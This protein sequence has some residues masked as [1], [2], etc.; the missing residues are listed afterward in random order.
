MYIGWWIEC[1]REMQVWKGK[2]LG[3]ANAGVLVDHF[4]VYYYVVYIFV[5]I[6]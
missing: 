2:M 1:V 3:K 5:Y 4:L 6:V